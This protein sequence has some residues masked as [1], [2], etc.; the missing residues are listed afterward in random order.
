MRVIIVEDES[1]A[2]QLI[3][4]LLNAVDERIQI[5][6]QADNAVDGQ[7]LIERLLPDAAFVDIKMPG[8]TGLEMIRSL[9]PK[10]LNVSF[11]IISG[12]GEFE[13]AQE[14]IELGIKSYILKPVSYSDIERVIHKVSANIKGCSISGEV[15]SQV[16]TLNIE[17]LLL[18]MDGKKPIVR[19]AIE[20]VCQNMSAACRLS[21]VAVYLKVSPEHLSRNF[22]EEMSITFM[23][24]VRMV[25][26]DYACVLLSKTQMR[27][28][29]IAKAVGYEND[30]Y[31]C[32]TFKEVIGIQPKKYR[33]Q[34]N[35]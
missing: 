23:A 6:G 8:M 25:K 7:A 20:Y 16:R 13:Y 22:H 26:M 33:E 18:N 24:F 28:Y 21:E 14:A 27:V 29:E 4:H 11:I 31:F 12:Y 1:K 17:G 34:Q 3:A 32:N 35:L 30:T 10:R 5:V 2:R 15:K 9:A 19:Q